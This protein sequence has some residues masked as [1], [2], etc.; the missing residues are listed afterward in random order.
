VLDILRDA[1][2]TGQG[3]TPAPTPTQTP[4]TAG[5]GGPT[6]WTAVADRTF[7]DW[8]DIRAI[9]YGMNAYGNNRFVAVG[10]RGRIAYST[11]AAN[12]TAVPDNTIWAWPDS[13]DER[14]SIRAIAIGNNRWVVGGDYGKIAYS[15]W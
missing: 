8:Y 5:D 15:D 14:V 11:D 10:S 6:N 13:P 4:A 7:S 1:G 2:Q 12:W 3:G 9:A